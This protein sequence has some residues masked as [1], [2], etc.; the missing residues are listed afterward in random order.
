MQVL[1]EFKERKEHRRMNRVTL[2]SLTDPPRAMHA[3]D[4]CGLVLE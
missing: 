3:L 1:E 2:L 4:C